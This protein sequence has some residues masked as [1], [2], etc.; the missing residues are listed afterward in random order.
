MLWNKKDKE[1]KETHPAHQG[2]MPN[3]QKKL[4]VASPEH[5]F[6]VCN[7]HTLETLLDLYDE[8][9]TIDEK[10][11]TVHVLGKRNDFANWVADILLDVELAE[12]L[13]RTDDI[14]EMTYLVAQALDHYEF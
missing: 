14:H 5:V 13:R 11:F 10:D 1:E 8:L 2:A 6:R 7:G 3:G 12:S 9:R 4:V